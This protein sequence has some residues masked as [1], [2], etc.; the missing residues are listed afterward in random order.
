MLALD[1]LGRPRRAAAPAAVGNGGPAPGGYRELIAR[2]VSEAWQ[3]I[4]HFAVT[5]EIDAE[6]LLASPPGASARAC[7]SR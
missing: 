2:K 1:R 4:P 5:R 3:T 7:P 6:E